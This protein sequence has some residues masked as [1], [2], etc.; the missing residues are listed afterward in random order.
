MVVNFLWQPNFH[1]KVF[2][3]TSPLLLRLTS[4]FT[5][6]TFEHKIEF[7][8]IPVVKDALTNSKRI[9]ELLILI[10]QKYFLILTKMTCKTSLYIKIY[11]TLRSAFWL[12]NI[13]SYFCKRNN[14]FLIIILFFCSACD[15]LK[16]TDMSDWL[17]H[18]ICLYWAY[19][20]YQVISGLGNPHKLCRPSSLVL[21]S[22]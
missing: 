1:R 13:V 20:Y 4:K 8:K 15:N 21:L 7:K 12:K 19:S 2:T 10:I 18:P 5:E 14:M 11:P 16:I 22:M 6:G 9:F 17:N 3:P